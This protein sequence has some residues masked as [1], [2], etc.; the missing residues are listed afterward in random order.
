MGYRTADGLFQAAN[1]S[2]YGVSIGAIAPSMQSTAKKKPDYFN[3][4]TP[5]FGIRA[6]ATYMDA[7]AFGDL[8]MSN[9]TCN[10]RWRVYRVPVEY[11]VYTVLNDRLLDMIQDSVF[12]SDVI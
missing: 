7:S 5:T 2:T 9:T 8:N 10:A 12:P 11:G 4:R 1:N 6:H 3:L